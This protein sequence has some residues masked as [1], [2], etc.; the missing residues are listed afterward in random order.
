MPAL[1]KPVRRGGAQAR[2][3]WDLAA[4]LSPSLRPPASRRRT[5]HVVRND[6][7]SPAS[8]GPCAPRGRPCLD[9]FRI[10]SS[11]ASGSTVSVTEKSIK[12]HEPRKSQSHSFCTS[13]LCDQHLGSQH[14][15]PQ[16]GPWQTC[17]GDGAQGLFEIV[18]C[19]LS[20]CHG[21]LVFTPDFYQSPA[22]DA[23]AKMMNDSKSLCWGLA[24]FSLPG[25]VSLTSVFMVEY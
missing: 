16:P 11:V 4:L 2:T 9:H 22:Q 3:S 5:C 23:K 19:Q 24:W 25:F 20:L 17:T 6:P 7:S 14:L 21:Y 15:V 18:Q 13:C 12:V 8:F 10:P 1:R